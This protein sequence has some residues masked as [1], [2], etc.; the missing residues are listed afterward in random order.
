MSQI[1]CHD[2]CGNVAEAGSDECYRHRIM[3]ISF[4]MRGPANVQRF[5]QTAR[6]WREENFGTS[7]ERE[8][9]KR[10]IERA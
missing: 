5:H 9:A 2:D 7:D 4:S 10:G 6:E 1:C 8:L 3:G